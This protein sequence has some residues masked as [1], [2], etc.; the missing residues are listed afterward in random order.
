M[1]ASV[2][3]WFAGSSI[4]WLIGG[5]LLSSV[6]P[7]TLI[8]IMPTNKKLLAPGLEKNSQVT[9]QLLSHWGKLHTVRNILS[10]LAL[11]IFLV[12]T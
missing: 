3:A 11:I 7:F 9:R 5:L 6:I 2:T 8:V 10:I 12:M 4:W 1:I